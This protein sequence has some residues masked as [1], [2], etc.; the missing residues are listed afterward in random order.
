MADFLYEQINSAKLFVES[1]EVPQF[2]KE[3]LS[4]N[5]VL[6]DY[7]VQAMSDTLLYLGNP[8]LSGN[9]QTH[10]LYHMATGSGKTVSMKYLAQY[11]ADNGGAVLAIN[12]KDIDFLQIF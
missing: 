5:I 11:F 3:N 12:V 9:K 6:R 1:P 7:Q 2:I 4:E 8:K 10:L